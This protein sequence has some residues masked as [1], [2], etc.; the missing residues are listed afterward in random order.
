MKGKKV[1]VKKALSKE[2]M[3]K[4]KT[5]GGFGGNQGGGDPWGNN[6]GGGWGGEI[7]FVFIIGRGILHSLATF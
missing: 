6:G 5:R 4:L 1:D 2:E 3:A 7:S